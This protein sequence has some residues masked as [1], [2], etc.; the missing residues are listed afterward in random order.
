MSSATSSA[1]AWSKL[2]KAYANTSRARVMSLKDRL[3]KI[4]KG[5]TSAHDY[6][7]SIHSIWDELALIGHPV[8]DL[9]LV[10]AALNGLRAQFREF[11]TSIRTKDSLLSFDEL[12]DKLVNFEIYMNHDEQQAVS[13]PITDNFAARGQHPN[14]RKNHFQ[15]EFQQSQ[16]LKF[17]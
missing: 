3:S 1:D 15:P 17:W 9:D 10:I 12:F 4:S 5:T 13:L 8:D 2:K 14:N 11:T 7:R 6:L 16:A